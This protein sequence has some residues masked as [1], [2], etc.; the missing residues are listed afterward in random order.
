MANK[1]YL[2]VTA[3]NRYLE[4]KFETDIHLRDVYLK[5]EISNLRLSKGIYYFQLKDEESEIAALLFSN[6]YNKLKFQ[7]ADGMKVVVRGRVSLYHRRGTY[8]ITVSE[9]EEVGLGDTYLNFLKLKEKLGNEGLFSEEYKKPIPLFSEKIGVITSETA[10]AFQDIRSTITKRYPLATIYLYKSLVQGPDAPNSLIKAIQKANDD[11]IVDVI[12]I[13]RGGGSAEDLS[14]FNNEALARAIFSSKIPIVSGVGHETDFTICDFVSDFRAPTPTGA[15]VKVTNDANVLKQTLSNLRNQLVSCA[16]K[17]L[18]EKYNT[19]QAIVTTYQFQSFDEVLGIKETS[20]DQLTYSL[21]MNSP[22]S[23]IE[24]ELKTVESLDKRLSLMDFP[25]KISLM[26]NNI[27]EIR[28]LMEKSFSR[29]IS[30]EENFLFNLIDK[31]IAINPLSLMKKGYTL[32]YQDSELILS[33]KNINMNKEIEI[34]FH[35]GT[36]LA[37]PKEGK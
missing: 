12:I 32:T 5:A 2:T 7:I 10:D 19:Y 33:S 15:A 4:V 29:K 6:S 27:E 35:D 18:T 26:E 13:A 11:N 37:I 1:Q 30:T 22:K 24:R 14:C 36:I 21:V 31:M 34:K 17:I 20:L 9:M 16:K 23:R 3:L 28:K 8:S 25:Q